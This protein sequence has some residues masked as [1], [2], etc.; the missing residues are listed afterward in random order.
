MKRHSKQR[1]NTSHIQTYE[2]NILYLAHQLRRVD[3]QS[4]SFQKH[5]SSLWTPIYSNFRVKNSQT[6]HK[7]LK[8]TA[9][10][11]ALVLKDNL[12]SSSRNHAHV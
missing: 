4:K 5:S 7:T 2:L 1:L 10:T 9:R 12:I 6:A 11:L 3:I 8:R